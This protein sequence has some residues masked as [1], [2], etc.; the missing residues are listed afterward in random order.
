VGGS[1]FQPPASILRATPMRLIN[2]YLIGYFILLIAALAALWDGGVLR[3]VS[4]VW[5]VIGLAVGVGFGILL[6]VS[7][8]KPN[9]TED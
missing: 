2:L 4:P 8:G 7:A 6:S 5:V 3:Q 9:V 1:R